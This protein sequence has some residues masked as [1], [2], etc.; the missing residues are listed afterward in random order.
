MSVAFLVCVERGSLEAQT[1][2]L[3]E[4][5]RRF[6]GRYGDAPVHAYR[7]RAGDPLPEATV[8]RLRDLGAELHEDTLNAEH[9]YDP[10]L[11]RIFV[12]RHAERTLAD[13][14]IVFCDSDAV[15]TG[16]P[17]GLD[18]G[19]ELDAAARPV[20][21]VGK[22]SRGPGD[23]RDEYWLRMYELAGVEARPFMR[24]G[25]GRRRI[26]AYWNAGLVATRRRAGV[27]DRWHGVLMRLLDAGHVPQTKRNPAIDQLSLAAT[28]SLAPDRTKTLGPAY[29]Y[30]IQ[31][32]ALLPPRLRR[33]D[34]TDIVHVHYHRW[35]NLPGFLERVE[36]P[37]DRT[38]EPFRW[39]AERLP[40]EPTID[41]PMHGAERDAI[42]RGQ[43][44]RPGRRNPYLGRSDERSGAG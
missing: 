36:P 30:P 41:E 15:F 1:I 2:L 35:F 4:S 5:L 24:T 34:L 21:E 11:N 39:L 33:M 6:G 23:R 10:M 28:L 29:N 40:L 43:R 13:D 20:G 7:P 31:K 12:G 18:I 44:P 22:G 16:E 3:V 42:P 9:D 8:E 37:L 26:R 27:F 14:V 25:I 19:P 32:R 17:R 38:S